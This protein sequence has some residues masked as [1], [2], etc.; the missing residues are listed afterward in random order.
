MKHS[1]NQKTS[2]L[3]DIGLYVLISLV[4]ISFPL[5][6]LF[7]DWPWTPFMHWFGFFLCMA[8]LLGQFVM[9]NRDSWRKRSYWLPMAS[10]LAINTLIFAIFFP[11][12]KQV[13][14]VVWFIIVSLETSLILWLSRTLDRNSG[15]LDS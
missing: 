5:C 12:D 11:I 14:V 13:P 3:K 7:L 1:G 2:R 9:N 8:F 10:L 6:A 4:V 15:S